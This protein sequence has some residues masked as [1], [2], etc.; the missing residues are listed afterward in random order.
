M[1]ISKRRVIAFS[2]AGLLLR[3]CS[4]ATGEATT[5]GAPTGM[6]QAAAF[7]AQ[8]DLAPNV[9]ALPR[10]TGDTSAIMAINADLDRFDAAARESG[11]EEGQGDFERGVSQPMTG[12]GFVTFAISE[13]FFCTGAARP[14]FS[15][16]AV[17][18]DLS[19]GERV[20]W[21][22]AVP[23]LSLTRPED[24]GLPATSVPGLQSATLAA[25][26]GQKMLAAP[27][28]EW[29][30]QCRSVFETESLS[31]DYFRIWADAEGGGIA[32]SAE[33]PHVV[34]ACAD[35]AVMTPAEMQQFGVAPA[36]IEAIAAANA[37]GNWAPKDA[38]RA[39]APPA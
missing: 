19:T 31:D 15:Q 18:Y 16:T 2:L 17:T 1:T 14:S 25:W 22:A 6:S 39:E 35:T 29:V 28:A 27:D 5:S 37:A 7:A 20:D 10:L 30:E 3:A 21:V 4:E 9:Q 24:D 38:A 32:V 11:C 26:Y 34:M 36:L 23:G 33:F 12:P 13:N 8:P